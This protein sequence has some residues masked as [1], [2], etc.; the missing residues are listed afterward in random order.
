MTTM[1]LTSDQSTSSW[2]SLYLRYTTVLVI[3]DIPIWLNYIREGPPLLM[4]ECTDCF[5]I[6]WHC[7]QL[8]AVQTTDRMDLPDDNVFGNPGAIVTIP[9][10]SPTHEP[11]LLSFTYF[12]ISLF[13]VD[14][15]VGRYDRQACFF[16]R[17]PQ[18]LTDTHESAIS[19]L[20]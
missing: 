17:L 1:L 12:T 5:M 16:V 10:R 4:A 18:P 7:S 15:S 8:E 2:S 9:A 19:P 14:H 11:S 3:W 6:P 13:M 20:K